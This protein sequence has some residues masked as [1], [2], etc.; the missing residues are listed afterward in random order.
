M[1][2]DSNG[3]LTGQ[4][5]VLTGMEDRAMTTNLFLISPGFKAHRLVFPI[6]L[7]LCLASSAMA[8][9]NRV[10]LYER[11]NYAGNVYCV[12]AGNGANDL[13]RAGGV[14]TGRVGSIR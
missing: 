10:C 11:P 8:Q 3:E 6:A 2:L 12:D 5:S 14:W 1:F 7:L 9:G 4:E 13:Q